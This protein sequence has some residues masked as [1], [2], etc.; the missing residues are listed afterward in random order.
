MAQIRQS[1]MFNG[2]KVER[3]NACAFFLLIRIS[4]LSSQG[5][6]GSVVFRRRSQNREKSCV[7]F[8]D[9]VYNQVI[10]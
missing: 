3:S 2:V 6:E 1:G 7:A 5:V 9:G 4:N 8:L 10:D